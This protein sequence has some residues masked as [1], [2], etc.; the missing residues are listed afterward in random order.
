M[1]EFDEIDKAAA[2]ALAEALARPRESELDLW[3]DQLE[4]AGRDKV[5]RAGVLAAAAQSGISPDQLR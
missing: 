1:N 4:L 5:A 3:R 2:E